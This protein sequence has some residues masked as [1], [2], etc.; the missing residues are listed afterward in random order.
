MA[1]GIIAE[2]N[3]FHNG[4]MHHLNQI[5]KKYPTEEIILVLSGNYTQRGEPSIIDKWKKCE[6]ALKAGIDL[7]V[8]LP[9]VFATQSADFFS[10]GA[11]SILETL[12]VERLIFG[13]ETNNIDDL[14]TIAKCQ[15]NNPE[16]NQLVKIYSK[17]G[18]NYPTALS[19]SVYDL[20]GKQVSTPNDLLGISYIKTIIENN[21]SIIPICIERTNN[22]H[23][24]DIHHIC[25]ATAIRNALKQKKNIEHT[26][27]KFVIPYLKNLHF[28]DDYFA[29]LKYKI[30]TEENLNQYQTVEEGLDKKL[31]KVI[32]KCYSYDELIAHVK[33]KRYTYNKIS[34]MLLHI[35]VGLTKQETNQMRK[36]EYIRILGFSP[37]G[38]QYLNHI[39]KEV[40]IELLSKFHRHHSKMLDV[41]LQ[42]T[43]IYSLP[44]QFSLV[45]MEYKNHFGKKENKC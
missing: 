3:P 9:F 27:P 43:S 4:H 39:K 26:V 24:K 14:I 16:F 29:L 8:E 17:L 13:S 1:I 18:E 6:I 38:Q 7:V 41:E 42:T 2:Y 37:K 22:Y 33:T 28:K 5:K 32:H 40:N 30:I 35:L 45:E 34:R 31:K 23:N 44:N 11:I 10:Y 21:F 19:K 15:I 12:K 36:L 25:S 20:T